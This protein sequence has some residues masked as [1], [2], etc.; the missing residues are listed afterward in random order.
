M[1][2]EANFVFCSQYESAD[3]LFAECPVAHA[4]WGWIANF[5][6]FTFHGTCLD[7]LWLIDS[8]VPLKDQALV[9]LVRSAVCWILW[10]ERNRCCFQKIKVCLLQSL[11]IRIINLASFWYK[12]RKESSFFKLIL[13][14][15]QEVEHLPL[16]IEAKEAGL[17]ALSEEELVPTLKT[18]TG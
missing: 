10:L 5:K 18:V 4:I 15:P 8:C 14:L 12:S 6:Q 1:A 9:E 3:H 13:V 11:G 17:D 16:Q 7:D 2:S